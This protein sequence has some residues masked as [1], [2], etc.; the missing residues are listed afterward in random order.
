[1][2]YI[3]LS[4]LVILSLITLCVAPAETLSGQEPQATI[5]VLREN[6]SNLQR[7]LASQKKLLEE[8]RAQIVAQEES[9]L[10]AKSKLSVEMIALEQDVVK[11]RSDSIKT[12]GI[13]RTRIAQEKESIKKLSQKLVGLSNQAKQQLAATGT[14]Q[15]AFDEYRNNQAALLQQQSQKV[16]SLK[17]ALESSQGIFAGQLKGLTAKILETQ[18]QFDALRQGMGGKVRRL[19]YW[20]GLMGLLVISGVVLGVVILRKMGGRCELLEG[21]FSRMRTRMEEDKVSLDRKLAELLES[22]MKVAGAPASVS[23]AAEKAGPETGIDHSLPLRVGAEILRLRQ[24]FKALPEGTKGLKPL[25]KSL[26]RLE[27]EFNQQGYEL[28]EMLGKPLDERLHV[29][30][31][32]IPSEDLVSGETLISKVIKPQIN[33]NGVSIQVAEIEVLTGGE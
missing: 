23:A 25:F 6:V 24:R 30:V 18:S 16:A 33:F 31:R 4:I 12:I 26:E 8:L 1:M 2:K 9:E 20:L 13:L 22:Q 10:N 27:D 32:F 11:L 14:L 29:K 5:G 21:D 17:M 15:K 7:E 19:T 28:V 3:T